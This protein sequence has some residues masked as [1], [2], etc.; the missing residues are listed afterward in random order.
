MNVTHISA[1]TLAVSDMACAISFY[2]KLGFTLTYGGDAT[3]F[4]TLQ[5]GDT[6]V[7]LSAT[8]D[9]EQRRW[10]RVIFRV[11]DVDAHHQ[12]LV[13]A[14]LTAESP[15]NAPWDKRYFHITDPDGHELSFA[16]LMSDKP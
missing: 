14:G 9:Y 4:S 6:F 13:E 3:P 1:V 10:G 7:N 5:A 8:P 12:A 16:Q 15:R 2:K 11:K